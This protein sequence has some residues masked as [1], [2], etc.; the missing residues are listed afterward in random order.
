ML[1][2][3]GIAAA[4]VSGYRARRRDAGWGQ[5]ER[6][7]ATVAGHV[8]PRN[9]WFRG[10]VPR[11]VRRLSTWSPTCLCS[12][13]QSPVSLLL[14]SGS[15]TESSGKPRNATRDDGYRHGS[16]CS[17]EWLHDYWHKRRPHHI[18]DHPIRL[19]PEQ[20]NRRRTINDRAPER[21][22][23]AISQAADVAPWVRARG[24]DG[25]LL[26]E[27]DGVSHS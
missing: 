21:A 5:R 27:L 13:P 3:L 4:N 8:R 26:R 25:Q 10:A 17:Y 2:G 20:H 9:A 16:G 23:L 11:R 12:P 6:P 19:R 7:S 22:P 1:L 18:T 14:S 24:V 15:A